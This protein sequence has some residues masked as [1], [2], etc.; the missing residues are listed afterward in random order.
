MRRKKGS[1][2]GTVL[3]LAAMGMTAMIG[4][5]GLAL[6]AGALYNHRRV[7]QTAADAGALAGASE[8]YR[9]KIGMVTSSSQTATA[10]NGF[11]HGT[12]GVTVTVNHPP[13]SGFYVGDAR[14]AEVLIS[15][16]SPTYFMQ[17][18]GF[19][20]VS[21][22]ARAVAGV[23]AN[24][25]NCVYV[26]DPSMPA[27]Y[28]GE[29][30]AILD[31]SCGVIVNSN[32]SRAI[33]VSSSSVLQATSV[34]T[35]G[36]YQ[37]NSSGRITPTPNVAVPPEPDPLAYLQPPSTAGCTMTGFHVTS[38]TTTLSPGVYCRGF[39]IVNNARVILRPGVY[40]IKG[41]GI[42]L[43]SNAILEGTGVTIFITEGAGFP[44]GTLSFQSSTQVR[45]T[46]PTEGPYA[47]ILFYQDPT[48]G[49]PNHSHHWESSTNSYFEG[50]LYFPTQQLRLHSSTTLDARYTLIVART[51]S[52]ESS[53]NFKV[54]SDYSGLSGGSP[55]KRISLVE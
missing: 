18:F 27:A 52:M 29:S 42:N 40:V 47:G 4:F 17:L 14:Y 15:Q 54:R 5:M 46:A 16:P 23:G 33:T 28:Q 24:G 53:A 6:D 20:S 25:K 49:T 31:A 8:I 2:T 21:V 13:T 37:L 55:I 22:P 1:E 30:S 9:A 41:G 7:M 34:S 35:T 12:G 44:Y 50:T 3:P 48:A 19:D 10:E 38:G 43:Q 39:S 51:I 26:L 32:N 11:T 45:L 36:N